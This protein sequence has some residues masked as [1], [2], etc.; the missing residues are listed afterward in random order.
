VS[1]ERTPRAL[2]LRSAAGLEA[3]ILD[4]GAT[5]A[6]LR[7]PDRHG[8]LGDVVL[9]FDDPRAWLGPHPC[10]GGLVG[11]YANR[12]A[13][14]RFALDG[15]EHRL[16]ANE[17]PHCLHGGDGFHRRFWELS[18]IGDGEAELRLVSPDGDQGFP[19]RLEV[20]V[21]Y[22]LRD[23]ALAIEIVAATDAPTIVS[24]TSHAYW[25]LE[26]GG[27]T[28]ILDHRL[29]VAAQRYT[30]IDRAG[31]PTGALAPVADTPLD[32]RAARAIGERIDVLVP[33]RGGYDHNFA[34]D[35]PVTSPLASGSLRGNRAA[36]SERASSSALRSAARLTAPRSGRTL[37]VRTTLPGLQ[38]YTGSCFDGTRAFR[39]G[40]RTP[41][42]GALALETQQFPNAPNEPGF[43]SA[44]LDPGE[45]WS[46]TTVYE[47]GIET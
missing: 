41:R 42:F 43:P 28:P 4:F 33:L 30:P 20:A 25:N 21:R 31:I 14:A 47:L 37:A 44:R 38:L 7:A 18:P 5:L 23:R 34:L 2:V 12:I 8:R 35:D 39:G 19:G 40:V 26:D 22:R 36:G 13:G 17:G 16:P 11:R 46:H 1:A 6:R 15:R 45:R 3:T 10:L 27:A 9:G 32:F 24:L 29:A